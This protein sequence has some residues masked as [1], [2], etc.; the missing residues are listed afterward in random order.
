MSRPHP[1]HG[2]R[3]PRQWAPCS[4]SSGPVILR[5]VQ[6]LVLQPQAPQPL[7]WKSCCPA[8][9]HTRAPAQPRAASLLC[10]L[11]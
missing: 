5:P 2:R 11:G 10:G 3:R 4:G 1:S 7:C 6:E 8:L 9:V